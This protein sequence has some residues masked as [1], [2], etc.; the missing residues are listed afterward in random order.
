MC[1]NSNRW[2]KTVRGTPFYR[3]VPTRIAGPEP[4]PNWAD[5]FNV[6]AGS[7]FKQKFAS[8]T[9]NTWVLDNA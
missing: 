1:T 6:T 4:S 9:I 5:P 2:I 8:Q 7:S 3:K